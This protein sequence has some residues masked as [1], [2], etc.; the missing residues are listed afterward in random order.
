MDHGL[1]VFREPVGF[2]VC[3]FISHEDVRAKQGPQPPIQEHKSPFFTGATAKA[4]TDSRVLALL[5]F[6]P[7]KQ[8]E[9]TLQ[10]L[11]P[12]FNWIQL[13]YLEIGT[14]I[15]IIAAIEQISQR[16]HGESR[17]A[18]KQVFVA[19]QVYLVSRLDWSYRSG[20]CSLN[21]AGSYWSV[22]RIFC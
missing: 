18:I 16:G 3:G 8:N 21:P 7:K 14:V 2:I 9:S 22:G 10:K 12:S 5:H 13:S 20:T 17:D 1:E 19:F 15:E 4:N 11:F 6:Q